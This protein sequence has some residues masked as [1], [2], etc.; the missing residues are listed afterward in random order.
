MQ[1]TS[2]YNLKK[3]EGT[4]P[5]EIQDINDNMEIIDTELK[6]KMESGSE[7]SNMI[8]KFSMASTLSA[9]VSGEKLTTSMGKIMKGISDLINHLGN[10]NN[11]HSVTKSQVGLG[12]V[13]NTSDAGKPVSTAMQSALDQKV[14]S[15]GGDISNTKVS[16]FTASTASYPVPAA[17]E[18]PKVFMGKVVKFFSDI[19]NW[20]TGVCLIGSI[21]NNCTSTRTDLPVSAAQAKNLMDLYTKLN[22]D[23]NV[24]NN[25]FANNYTYTSHIIRSDNDKGNIFLNLWIENSSNA[26]MVAFVFSTYRYSCMVIINISEL[27]SASVNSAGVYIG[28][29]VGTFFSTTTNFIYAQQLTTGFRIK[30]KTSGHPA[31]MMFMTPGVKISNTSWNPS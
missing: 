15:S 19:K 18:T 9:L 17:G 5:I 31:D 20:M 25:I 30:I 23:L 14:A 6:K 27:S 7:A 26:G 1:L 21:V 24:I 11:P 8:T 3:P 12:S 4:D 10:K 22:S 28:N 2:N 13:D 29:T 16:S